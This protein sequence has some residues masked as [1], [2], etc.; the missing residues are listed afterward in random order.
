M[1]KKNEEINLAQC[2]E[3]LLKHSWVL[4]AFVLLGLLGAVLVNTFMRPAYQSTALLM[5]NQEQAGKIETNPYTSFSSAEDYYRTQ[6]KLLESRN[7]LQR[8]YD[9]MDLNQYDE[10]KNPYGWK[11]LL[12]SLKVVPVLRSRLV[13]VSVTT[14]DRHL[15][16][17]IANEIADTFVADNVKNRISMGADVIRALES[18]ERSRDDQ[19]LLNSMPQV[20]NSDFIKNLKLQ[21]AQL[22]NKQAQYSAKY[23]QKH[24][25][26]ISLNKQLAAVQNKIALETRRLVQSIKIELSG[27]FSGNNIRVVDAAVAAESPV[28]PRKL[29]NLLIGMS[30][31]GLL[32]LGFVLVL[33]YLDQT[34]Q[35]AEDLEK[36]LRVAFLG[37]V[38]KEKTKKNEPEYAFMTK[39]GHFLLAE[40]VR[41]IRTMLAFTLTKTPH[42][43]ILITSA[44]Q[45]EGKS[46][47]STNLAVALAQTGKKTLLIDGDL[48]R[49]RLHKAFHLSPDKGLSNLWVKEGEKAQ[50]S[51]NVQAVPD[52]ENL[53]VMTAGQR[54]PNP[55]ELLNSARLADLIAWAEKNYDQVLVDCPAIVPVSDTL[56]WG[57]YIPRAVFVLKQGQTHAHLAAAA[58]DKL[59]KAG[60]EVLGAVLGHFQ[61]KAMSYSKYGYYKKSYQYYQTDEKE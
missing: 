18:T 51:Y 31:G 46:H 33:S 3:I 44:L 48:R 19:E 16:A 11:K 40:N 59:N 5:I 50:Y 47:L 23:T 8:V 49:S 34:I 56:L 43:P 12:K 45:G 2:F 36:K 4:M 35:N 30:A 14:Y 15:S 54:P 10:F 27:Q 38:P 9:K 60:I 28:R 41:N 37:F 1:E 29:L 58:M 24:P 6:Y 25:E 57:R 22:L 26:V 61:P 52:V 55:A 13:Q 7:L 32:G 53:F 20:V 17:E 39:E 21:E 42:A